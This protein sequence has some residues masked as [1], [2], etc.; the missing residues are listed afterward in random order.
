MEH[1]AWFFP[2]IYLGFFYLRYHQGAKIETDPARPTTVLH[3]IKKYLSVWCTITAY[4]ITYSEYFLYKWSTRLQSM[5]NLMVGCRLQ[6]ASVVTP[7]YFILLE[8]PHK[9]DKFHKLKNCLFC[10]H[11][12]FSSIVFIFFSRIII[13][14][15]LI[16]ANCYRIQ[17]LIVGSSQYF[18]DLRPNFKEFEPWL[19]FKH[20]LKYGWFPKIVFNF[21]RFE[22][23]LNWNCFF[24]DLR[25]GSN[26]LNS[27][28]DLL[29]V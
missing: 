27:D 25:R 11:L 29:K 7:F 28:T 8:I 20:R 9:S 16:K 17:F 3:L 26:S 4:T 14:Q 13:L 2:Q 22:P 18:C 15:S 12:S 23:A 1:I 6:A 10:A 21:S 19:K 24:A 5:H